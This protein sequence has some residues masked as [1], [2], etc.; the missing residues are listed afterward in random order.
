MKLLQKEHLAIPVIP[1]AK[2]PDE[3]FPGAV[4]TF[5]IEAMMQDG[6]AVQS[7][8]SH[9]LG[10]NFA[11][12]SGIKFQN[13]NSEEVFAWT[14]SWGVSTRLI[15]ALIM[16]H[17][18]DDGLVVPPKVAPQHIVIQPIYKN[19]EQ[20]KEI[21]E[22]CNSIVTGLKTQRFGEQKIRV[23][24]DDRDI[25]GGEK[26]WQNI[27]KGVPIRLEIGPRDM[28]KGN[29]FMGRRDLSPKEKS[30]LSKDE[31]IEKAV[32]ILEEIQQN[33]YNKALNFRNENTVEVNSAEEFETFFT[34]E[35]EA[36][37]SGG[38]AYANWCEDAIDHELLNK[39]KVTPRCIT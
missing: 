32:S 33:I 9:F 19:P 30:S 36:G 6:K 20:R 13:E 17:S 22:F 15:G 8:T 5:T 34:S 1:G 11:K 21:L 10:Q 35:K 27:K 4:D 7:G 3:R 37:F 23:Y 2:T 28:A 18:D 16:T 26:T 24:I 29:V 31:F 12:A 38:F 14:T 39:L 25:R